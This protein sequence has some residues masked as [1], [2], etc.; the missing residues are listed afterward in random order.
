MDVYRPRLLDR[1]IP[2]LL[3]D[4]PAVMV[5]GARATGKTTTA[6]RHAATVVRLDREAEAVAFRADP[7][8]AL[9]N[10]REPV[11][12]D[13]WQAVPEVLGAVKRSVDSDPR[14]GRFLLTGSVRAQGD[15][16]GWP[17]VGRVIRVEMHPLTVSERFGRSPR[18]LVDRIA[19]GE[20]LRPA[21]D[22]PDLR[23]VLEL[24]LAGGFP[25]PAFAPSA[26]AS[27]RWYRSYAEHLVTRNPPGVQNGRDRARLR[28][29]LGACALN[30][31][32]MATERTL[33]E[34]AGINQRTGAAYGR[35][36]ESLAVVHALPAWA[37]N[38]LKR[39]TRAP[40][41]YL[42]DAGLLAAVVR[43]DLE[44]VLADGDLLGRVLDTFVVA[45]LRAE[46]AVAASEPVL[47]HLRQEQGRR[48]VDVLAELIGGRVVGFEIKASAAPRPGDA[49]HLLWL[50]D[51]LGDRFLGGVVLHT[52][53]HRYPLGERITAA[54]VSTLW[55]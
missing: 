45:Q 53:P 3:A 10:R 28:R 22:P 21:A 18:P 2:G 31:A 49:R 17:G 15:A 1:H 50:R 38:R 29:F 35:F 46:A 20:E 52:G 43:A 47:Y 30:S 11:L 9:R 25:E 27:R 44:S 23:G 5:T 6:I 39:L 13:E 12:L 7:D 16:R 8:A 4:H 34:A 24:A 48:E 37:S 26:E 19:A 42:A 55:G 32:G 36:L 51:E 40:K 14:P 54:P 33:H 41:R